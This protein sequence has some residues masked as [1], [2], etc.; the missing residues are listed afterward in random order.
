MMKKA[1]CLPLGICL[2]LGLCACGADEGELETAW[3]VRQMAAVIWQA[4]A[5]ASGTELL[6]EDGVYETYLTANYGLEAGWVAEGA[7]WVAGGTSAQE[8]AVFRLTEDAD[9][10]A[11]VEAL[12]AYLENRT[13]AFTGYLPEEA[14]LLENAAV[15]SRGAYVALLACEDVSAAQDAFT[16]CF[17]GEPPETV[18][19]A[20]APGRSERQD[21][22]APQLGNAED[23]A[24]QDAAQESGDEAESQIPGERQEAGETE[25]GALVGTPVDSGQ[26]AQEQESAASESCGQEE[27]LWTYDEDRLLDAWNAGDWS[28]LAPEDR[29]I[30]DACAEV[31]AAEVPAD[32]SEYEQELAVHDWMIAHGRYDSSQLSWLSDYREN[33]NNTNPYGFL[34]DGVGICMGYTATFQLFMDLLGIECITVEGTAYS[35]TADHAWNQVKLEGEWYCVDV[36]WDDPTTSGTVSERSAHRFFNVTSEY[37]RDTDHQWDEASVPEAAGTAC[38]WR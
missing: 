24:P 33:P 12:Q 37:M 20:A 18:L 19:P 35:Y 17:S 1:L 6:P 11:A 30:L 23:P 25:D 21:T 27:S 3:T 15:V 32:G 10:A 36:T 4:G 31:I 14:A 28:G 16:C 26:P 22:K 29:A 13:G 2:L 34:A 7:V 8:T 9:G 5:Q 38:T